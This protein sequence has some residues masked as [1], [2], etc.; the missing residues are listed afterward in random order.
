MHRAAT[1]D[2]RKNDFRAIPFLCFPLDLDQVGSENHP[3][4]SL[5]VACDLAIT[6]GAEIPMVVLRGG[7]HFL[8]KTL[9]LGH[10][11]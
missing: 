3:V 2:S 9:M 5:Q 11:N 1:S 8:M 6:R 4:R 7:T 10:L